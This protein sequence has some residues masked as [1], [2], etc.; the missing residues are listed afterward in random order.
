LL[1]EKYQRIADAVPRSEVYNQLMAISEDGSRAELD[2][3]IEGSLA[4]FEYLLVIHESSTAPRLARLGLQRI[5]SASD[6]DLYR[7]R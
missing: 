1:T 7:L 4:P 5:A 2:H 6:F 3:M